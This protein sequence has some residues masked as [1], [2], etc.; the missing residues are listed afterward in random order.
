MWTYLVLN[1]L[2]VSLL[3]ESEKQALLSNILDRF[4]KLG[5]PAG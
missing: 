1:A 2:N 3:P 4:T 5:S